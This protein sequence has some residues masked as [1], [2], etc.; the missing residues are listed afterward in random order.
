M[1]YG[2]LENRELEFGQNKNKII[3]YLKQLIILPFMQLCNFTSE[4]NC[5]HSDESV[6]H[7]NTSQISTIEGVCGIRP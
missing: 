3:S 5:K 7:D 2:E 6:T 1:H 4:L